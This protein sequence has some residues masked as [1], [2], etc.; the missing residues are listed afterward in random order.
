MEA[1]KTISFLKNKKQNQKLMLN[2]Y[3]ILLICFHVYVHLQYCV[4]PW[5]EQFCWDN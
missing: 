2:M 1:V 3:L 4:L 5:Q